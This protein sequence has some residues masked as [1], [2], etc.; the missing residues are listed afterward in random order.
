MDLYKELPSLEFT[1]DLKDL[2]GSRT[3]LKYPGEF[4]CKIPDNTDLAEMDKRRALM[5]LGLD[6]NLEATTRLFYEKLSYLQCIVLE[7]PDWWKQSNKGA[8]L[9]DANII[10]EMYDQAVEA[11]EK[12]KKAVWGD[13]PEAQPEEESE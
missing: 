1:I 11:E 10:A 4:K 12:W 3:N 9:L 2:R 13:A 7:G 6:E 5:S 8:S